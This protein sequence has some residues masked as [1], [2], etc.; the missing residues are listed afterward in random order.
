MAAAGRSPERS[1]EV[2]LLVVLRSLSLL[3]AQEERESS[4]SPTPGLALPLQLRAQRRGPHRT[5][6]ARRAREEQSAEEQEAGRQALLQLP[7]CL[8]GAVRPPLV[9]EP[10]SPPRWTPP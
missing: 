7:P 2:S 8:P 3:A 6:Q 9:P 5:Q 4:Q 1:P 10:G